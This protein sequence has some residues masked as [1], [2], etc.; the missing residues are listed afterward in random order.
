MDKDNNVEKILEEIEKYKE[1]IKKSRDTEI[2][3]RNKINELYFKN[4]TFEFLKLQDSYSRSD[5]DRDE[6][7]KTRSEKL[8]IDYYLNLYL[9]HNV[10]LMSV[11]VGNGTIISHKYSRYVLSSGFYIVPENQEY[12][13]KELIKEGRPYL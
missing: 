9:K 2:E 3:H 12:W 11:Y 6:K 8:L 10:L 4:L 13:P 5:K 1:E 7:S